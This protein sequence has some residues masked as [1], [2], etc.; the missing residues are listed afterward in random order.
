M[1]KYYCHE[2]GAKLGKINPVSEEFCATGNRYMLEKF[3]K[4]TVPPTC[5]GLISI[6][7]EPSYENYKNYILY[8]VASGCIE[9]DDMGRENIIW[10]AGKKTGFTFKDGVL[11]CPT[12]AIKVVL[13]TTDQKI[14]AFPVG[15]QSL[16]T[17]TCAICG[18][19]IIK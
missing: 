14:H 10:T 1:G 11:Q 9:V 16:G 4:H 3:Y 12:D 19:P 8:T 5:S 2:C 18:K 6:F 17:E 15:S 13:N 7:D